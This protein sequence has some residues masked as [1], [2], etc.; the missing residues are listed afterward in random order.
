MQRELIVMAKAPLPDFAKSRLVEPI[1]AS[2]A[3]APMTGAPAAAGTPGLGRFDTA[4]VARLADAFIRDTLVVCERCE[5]EALSIVFAPPDSEVYFRA[6][7]PAVALVPQAG[8]DL[9]AR[10]AAA[11]ARK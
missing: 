6:V 11:T 8:G 5:H 2:G 10:M 9:G 1:P 3:L 4:R 7:A